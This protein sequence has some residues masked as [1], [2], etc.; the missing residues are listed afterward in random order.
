MRP[1]SDAD[2]LYHHH[3]AINQKLHAKRAASNRRR[4]ERGEGGEMTRQAPATSAASYDSFRGAFSS[5]PVIVLSIQ[6]GAIRSAFSPT[7]L[8]RRR[9]LR[10]PASRAQKGIAFLVGGTRRPVASPH[11]R[12]TAPTAISP[13]RLLLEIENT[14]GACSC[15]PSERKN[16]QHMRNHFRATATKS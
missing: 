4:T 14:A 2:S 6:Q 15:K 12:T 5:A 3:V 9:T 13:A 11:F 16:C 8:Q 1:R 7:R 10:A